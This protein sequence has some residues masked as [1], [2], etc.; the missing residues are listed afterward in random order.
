MLQFLYLK[1]KK[2]PFGAEGVTTLQLHYRF[3]PHHFD[4]SIQ[5]LQVFQ[6]FILLLLLA[7]IATSYLQSEAH[8]G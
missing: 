2:V 8:A 6:I 5:L 3:A 7:P 1:E 4:S